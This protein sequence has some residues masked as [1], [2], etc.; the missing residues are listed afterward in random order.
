MEGINEL[1]QICINMGFN[2][3]IKMIKDVPEKTS[4]E[5]LIDILNGYLETSIQAMKEG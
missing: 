1:Q 3:A 5:E 4:K 2:M